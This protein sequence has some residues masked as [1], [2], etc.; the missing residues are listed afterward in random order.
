MKIDIQELLKTDTLTGEIIKLLRSSDL[1]DVMGIYNELIN[2]AK[3]RQLNK[4][5]LDGYFETHHILP[6]CLGGTDSAENL[7]LLNYKE[8]TIAHLLLHI[9]H[10]DN[11]D[12]ARAI[13]FLIDVKDY[14][15]FVNG[16]IN[17]LNILV[18][19]TALEE[20]KQ[21]RSK[22]MLGDNNPMKNPEIAKKVSDFKKGKPSFFK[23]KHHS[24][25]T[26]QLLSER[27]KQLNFVGK[28]HP[29]YGK[30]HSPETRDVLSKKLSGANH[31][32]FGKHLSKETREKMS[33]SR[34][35]N[36]VFISPTGETFPTLAA[37]ARFA[38]V[39]P[40]TLRRW[41]TKFPEKG[42]KKLVEV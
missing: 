33:K 39:H 13:C 11:I 35:E 10:Q 22:I 23:G 2:S 24:E 12:L 29:M 28:N 42:W 32:L 15:T 20:L 5:V 7:V 19:I 30:T 14:R 6:R 25:K 8:H 38:N 34:L 31:P 37:A 4:G 18:D 27:T 41:I 17:G 3:P 26:K 9:L 21:V 16:D 36:S 1:N 40:K